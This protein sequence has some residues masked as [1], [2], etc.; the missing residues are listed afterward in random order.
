MAADFWKAADV[1]LAV[2]K[3]S[4]VI[5]FTSSKMEAEAVKE[6]EKKKARVRVRGVEKV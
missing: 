2:I 1:K 4:K 5:N 3:L 6:R